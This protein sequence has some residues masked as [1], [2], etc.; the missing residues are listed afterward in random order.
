[1]MRFPAILALITAA[2]LPAQAQEAA[3][4]PADLDLAPLHSEMEAFASEIE[5][6]ETSISAL[7]TLPEAP[8]DPTAPMPEPPPG[9][10]AAVADG[11]MLFD[12]AHSSLAYVGN[13]RLNDPR[14]QL[15]AAHRL[16]IVMPHRQQGKEAS[17]SKEPTAKPT[18]TAA[19]KPAPAPKKEQPAPVPAY[20]VVENAAVDALTSRV[21]LQG[22]AAAPSLSVQRGEDSLILQKTTQG[23]P[24]SIFSNAQGD[25]LMQGTGLVLIGHTQ[26]GEEWKLEAAT[27]PVYYQA[28]A[29]TLIVEGKARITSP[30]GTIDSS[31]KLRVVFAASGAEPADRPFGAFAAMQFRELERVNAWGDVVLHAPAAEG[32]P[33][34]QAKGEH[35]AYEAATGRCCIYGAPSLTYGAMSAQAQES[36]SYLVLEENGDASFTHTTLISGTYERP[37]GTDQ[38]P[39]IAG[40]W[41]SRGPAHYRAADNTITFPAGFE[42][43]DAHASFCCT[44]ELVVGLIAAEGEQPQ[45]RRG[46]PNLAAARQQGISTI[47]ARGNVRLHSDAVGTT[48]ACDLTADELKTHIPT[49][50]T[51]L[52]A[53]QGR[54]AKVAYNGYRLSSKATEQGSATI[55]LHPNGDILALGDQISATLPGDKGTTHATCRNSLQLQR[56]SGLVSLGEQSRLDSPDGIM[57]A[58]GPMEAQ[59]APGTAP[60]RAPKAYP[61]LDYNYGGLRSART[62]S[63]GTMRTE[64][65]SM[66]CRGLIS[67]EL[68]SDPPKDNPRQAIRSATAQDHVLLAGKDATGRLVCGAGDRLDFDPA[69]QNFYLRGRIVSLADEYNTHISTGEGARI[70]IDPK[71]NVR[72]TGKH[73]TTHAT[74]IQTQVDKNKKK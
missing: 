47:H 31:R 21:L 25:V 39:P 72:I 69:T 48:P 42:A 51:H 5:A 35:L 9:Q 33:A 16:Y 18:P 44:D 36:A 43:R 8:Y 24:A 66:Q 27:G 28:A 52:R 23:E 11:G 4:E 40:T 22:R 46:M 41:R 65:V 38:A 29:R 15:R 62:S 73:Q 49:A 37:S 19:A 61:Q 64:Q 13:V 1:M 45:P 71:N 20:A 12:N 56:E 57:T 50:A 10:S 55:D 63:G 53:E 32:R 34:S 17:S 3:A 67:I 2:L 7:G 30:R 6:M 74:Q 26:E 59:L 14:L 58:Q 70:T 68:R 60:S 54:S